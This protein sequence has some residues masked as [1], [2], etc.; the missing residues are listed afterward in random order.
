MTAAFMINVFVQGDRALLPE[1]GFTEAGMYWPYG[2]VHVV[3]LQEQALVGKINQL[4]ARGNP[5]IPHPPQSE[6]NKSTTIQ[7]AIGIRSWKKMARE[8][9]ICFVLY[10]RDNAVHL[11]RSP[12]DTD[13]IL[14]V[15]YRNSTAFPEDTSIEEIVRAM[16]RQLERKD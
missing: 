11:A 1:L 13:N 10:S 7:K 4:K 16:L 8:G 3:D 14:L 2:S 5:S 9:I 15:D 6:L 12:A